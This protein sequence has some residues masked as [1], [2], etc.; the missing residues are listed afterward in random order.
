VGFRKGTKKKLVQIQ[1]KLNKKR[2]PGDTETA[3]DAQRGIGQKDEEKGEKEK[4]RSANS[5]RGSKRS[6]PNT[7][8]NEK[9]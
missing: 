7:V 8:S 2:L 5:V 6:E 3:T 1:L 4:A 9:H